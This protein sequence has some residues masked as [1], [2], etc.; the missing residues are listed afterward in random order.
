M[1]KQTEPG[2]KPDVR[3]TFVRE[4]AKDV[5]ILEHMIAD[6]ETLI[7]RNTEASTGSCILDSIAILL[8]AARGHYREEIESWKSEIA[9]AN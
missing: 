6:C 5:S 8:E 9:N 7:Q 3:H 2:G 4:L 1:T